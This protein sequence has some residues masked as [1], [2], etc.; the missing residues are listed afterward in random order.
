MNI[1]NARLQCT[2]RQSISDFKGQLTD[3]Q[4][5]AKVTTT[6]VDGRKNIDWSKI[7]SERKL[8]VSLWK[9]QEKDGSV[10]LNVKVATFTFKVTL[11]SF[12]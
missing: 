3:V 7:P 4:D 11:P 5:V 2:N 6:G 10:T 9:N 8:S 12:S 1:F